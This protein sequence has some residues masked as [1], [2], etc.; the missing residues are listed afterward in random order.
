[1]SQTRELSADNLHA[2]QA[3]P[4]LDPERNTSEISGTRIF[5]KFVSVSTFN[6]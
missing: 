6:G 2:E 4:R 5:F 3:D 1:M